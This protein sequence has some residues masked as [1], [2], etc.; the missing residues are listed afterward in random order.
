MKKIF[1]RLAGYIVTIY[2]NRIYRKAVQEAE[3]IHALRMERIY[4]ASSI[5]DIRKLVI[6]NRYKFRQIK[7]KLFIR[8][9]YISNLKDGAWYY[10]ADRS[11]KNG[12]TPQEKEARRLSFVRHVLHRAKLL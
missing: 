3:K 9:F 11:G 10:T 8:D 7:K 5:E 4:V 1:R 12:M 2:A 6:Y